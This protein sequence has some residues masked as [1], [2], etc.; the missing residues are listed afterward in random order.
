MGSKSVIMKD[1]I[2]K[3][4]KENDWDWASSISP[5]GFN[6]NEKWFEVDD[7]VDAKKLVN[8]FI[9]LGMSNENENVFYYNHEVDPICRYVVLHSSWSSPDTPP[10]EGELT[11]W[12]ELPNDTEHIHISDATIIPKR[13]YWDDF[14]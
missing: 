1:L 11:V 3:I 13:V 4:L 12:D 7:C 5:Y 8:K 14:F 6:G 9:E 10:K 2:K